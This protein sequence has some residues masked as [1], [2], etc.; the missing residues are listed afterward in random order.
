MNTSGDDIRYLANLR[1]AD[2]RDKANPV[3]A[4]NS[5]AD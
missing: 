3:N 5:A 2:L 1:D 4:K